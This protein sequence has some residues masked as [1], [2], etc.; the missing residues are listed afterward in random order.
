MLDYKVLNQLVIFRKRNSI[1]CPYQVLN[2]T[3]EYN[4]TSKG[5]K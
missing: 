4:K 5:G 2:I 3:L 1:K